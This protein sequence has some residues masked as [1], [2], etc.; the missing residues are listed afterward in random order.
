MQNLNPTLSLIVTEFNPNHAHLV[1]ATQQ[2]ILRL[3][4]DYKSGMLLTQAVETQFHD[5]AK[6][7]GQYV[8]FELTRACPKQYPQTDLLKYCEINGVAVGWYRQLDCLTPLSIRT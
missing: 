3:N 1:I 2:G 6:P 4:V 7:Y 8:G 5:L